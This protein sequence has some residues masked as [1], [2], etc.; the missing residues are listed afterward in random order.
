MMGTANA[1]AQLMQLCQTQMIG[2]VYN[3]SIGTRDINTRFNNSGTNQY[4][5]SL[6]IKIWTKSPPPKTVAAK[7]E[8]DAPISP[9]SCIFGAS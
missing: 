4:I 1:A 5:L 6:M 9:L 3:N 7:N 8:R 2:A